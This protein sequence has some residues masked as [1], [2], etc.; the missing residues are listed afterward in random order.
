MKLYSRV[1]GELEFFWDSASQIPLLGIAV[2][3]LHL[4]FGGFYHLFNIQSFQDF[5]TKHFTDE[6]HYRNLST[7]MVELMS[8]P[9]FA[10]TAL[11]LLED[12]EKAF[13][14]EEKTG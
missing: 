13:I 3:A 5:L 9:G 14:P 10:I 2:S 6:D 11:R 8:H 7:K 12:L 4:L 1:K